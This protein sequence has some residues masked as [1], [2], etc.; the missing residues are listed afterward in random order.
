M[1]RGQDDGAVIDHPLA[2]DNAEPK[3]NPAQQFGE[4]ITNPVVRIQNSL[5]DF[6][7]LHLE[8]A[9]DLA[10]HAFDRQVRAIDHMCVFRND[11][12]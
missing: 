3:K 5:A 6:H 9:D 7:S 4:V 12:R 2:M 1:I 8:A 11:E 10:D